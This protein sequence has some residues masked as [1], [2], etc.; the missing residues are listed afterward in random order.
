MD[1]G[2]LIDSLEGRID[3]PVAPSRFL[4]DLIVLL[5]ADRGRG[6]H[7]RPTGELEVLEDVGFGSGQHLLFHDGEQVIVE[8]LLLLVAELLEA[9]EGAVEIL[10]VEIDP[11]VLESLF[12][13]VAA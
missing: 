8:D 11:Q 4:K 9:D 7:I 10:F 1:S 13:R 6:D 5:Q 2:N 12:E 3:R